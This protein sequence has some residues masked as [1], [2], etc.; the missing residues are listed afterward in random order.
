VHKIVAPTRAFSLDCKTVYSSL[1]T[2]AIKTFVFKLMRTLSAQTIYYEQTNKNIPGV[3]GATCNKLQLATGSGEPY[4]NRE[5]RAV[6]Q[7][8]IPHAA[9]QDATGFG[10]TPM[11]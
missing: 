10:M 9:A 7:Q 1:K 11:A 5:W 4:G 3:W 2:G 6:R 8:Q